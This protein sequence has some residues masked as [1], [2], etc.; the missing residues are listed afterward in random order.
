[1]KLPPEQLWFAEAILYKQNVLLRQ[2]SHFLREDSKRLDKDGGKT[3][4]YS[5]VH[6]ESYRSC[7]TTNCIFMHTVHSCTP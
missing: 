3:L 4:L 5:S 2:Q 7:A 1:M 6:T